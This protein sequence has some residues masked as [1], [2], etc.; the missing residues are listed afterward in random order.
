MTRLISLC[1]L[2]F[3]LALFATAASAQ[4]VTTR[5][6]AMAPALGQVLRGSST[7]QFT[8]SPAGVVT[9]LSGDAIRLSSANV[10]APTITITCGLLNLDQLCALRRMRVTIT[11]SGHSADASIVKFKVANLSGGLFYLTPPAEAS[12]V[13]FDLHP[14][15]VLGSVNFN[16]G[17][18]VELAP[19]TTT[20]LETFNYTVQAVLL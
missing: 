18:T 19:G 9:R 7:T 11:A 17:M 13:I 12:V 8:I 4:V 1:L 20:G 14:I 3:G 6:P 10:T 5:S 16:L 15:G 2:S